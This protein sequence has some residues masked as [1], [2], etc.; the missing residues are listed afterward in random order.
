LVTD[1]FP[2][3]A[4]GVEK[5]DPEIM[6]IPPRNSNEPILDKGMVR[7]IIFQSIAIAAGSLLAYIWGLKTYGMDNLIIARTMTF[8][9]L[10][11]AELLRAFSSRSE[12]HTIFEIGVFSNKKLTYATLFSLILL[13]VVI[14]LPILQPIFD[15][16]PL[17]FMDWL[18]VLLLSFLPLLV[19]EVYKIF[20][21][22]NL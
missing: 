4:L 16:Y 21:R 11:T 19:G 18:I 15:T 5:G 8:A 1:S 13:I 2:A 7:A 6:K 10:I 17:G 14:Y 12:R 3:L 22:K 9:T 20:T